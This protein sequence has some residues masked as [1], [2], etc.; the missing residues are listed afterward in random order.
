MEQPTK[1]ARQIT[2]RGMRPARRRLTRSTSALHSLFVVTHGKLKAAAALPLQMP[3]KLC[4]ARFRTG[5]QSP[6]NA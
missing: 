1:I 2:T 3:E 5:P 4:D 6:A